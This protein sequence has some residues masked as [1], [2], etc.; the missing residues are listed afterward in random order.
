MKKQVSTFCVV[1]CNIML[2]CGMWSVSHANKWQE[3]S[4]LARSWRRQC[5]SSWLG[6]RQWTPFD[7]IWC[8]PPWPGS[9]QSWYVLATNFAPWP[10]RE[11]E[12]DCVNSLSYTHFVILFWTFFAYNKCMGF[13]RLRKMGLFLHNKHVFFSLHICDPCLSF[14]KGWPCRWKSIHRFIWKCQ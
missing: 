6:W 4:N 2:S 9:C 1:F 5:H 10:H 3:T 14:P 13:E 11:R 7:F 8:H 12:R